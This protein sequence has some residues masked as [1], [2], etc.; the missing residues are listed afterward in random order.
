[1]N[2]FSTT[3]ELKSC[4]AR[5]KE[6]SM[7]YNSSFQKKK[8]LT[9]WIII[10][11]LDI[12]THHPTDHVSPQTAL[13]TDHSQ[14]AAHMRSGLLSTKLLSDISSA[15]LHVCLHL[16]VPWPVHYCFVCGKLSFPHLHWFGDSM[17]AQWIQIMSLGNW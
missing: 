15:P 16:N 8:I 5:E 4:I 12:H 13:N 6:N 11:K 2:Q 1:M 17:R 9:E 10:V 7:L 14:D 3:F